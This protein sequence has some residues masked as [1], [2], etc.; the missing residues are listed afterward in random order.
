M[1]TT[2][3]KKVIGTIG[4]AAVVGGAVFGLSKAAEASKVNAEAFFEDT[5]YTT[6]VEADS[7][8][9]SE[10]TQI[11]TEAID[12]T[13]RFLYG[14]GESTEAEEETEQTEESEENEESEESTKDSSTNSILAGLEDAANNAQNSEQNG[15]NKIEPDPEEETTGGLVND[16][17]KDEETVSDNYNEKNPSNIETGEGTNETIK[18]T[19]SD[20][21][22]TGVAPNV[23]VV[24]GLGA[25]LL[26]AGGIGL[27]V[28]LG[29][30]NKK[31]AKVETKLN[32]D[33]NNYDSV[34]DFQRD[35]EKLYATGNQKLISKIKKSFEKCQ[36]KALNDKQEAVLKQEYADRAKLNKT[37]AK[38]NIIGSEYD[39]DSYKLHVESLATIARAEEIGEKTE[40]KSKKSS[41]YTKRIKKVNE[42]NEK[43]NEKMVKVA[44]GDMDKEV[45]F[46]EGPT[47]K[48]HA[49]DQPVQVF[50]I[51]IK[52]AVAH[53]T[54][55]NGQSLKTLISKVHELFPVADGKVKLCKIDLITESGEN[56]ELQCSFNEGAG[57][58]I[59][60]AGLFAEVKKVR[61]AR[62][63]IVNVVV[64]ETEQTNKHIEKGP[65]TSFDINVDYKNNIAGL[66]KRINASEETL[67][68]F[69]KTYELVN[70][71]VFNDEKIQKVVKNN[72][73]QTL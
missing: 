71:Y 7:S 34:V 1:A 58:D 13:V 56:L 50:P 12:H 43:A 68:K 31:L 45:Y 42:L 10:E 4:I 32:A 22:R 14:E 52:R 60:K 9:V 27:G 16:A 55:I 36:K 41:L 72:E 18:G 67:N 3:F 65:K 59:C 15:S 25:G 19:F 17:E 8:Y 70:R 63:D 51:N 23:W 54:S 28:G 57:Y 53:S 33:T 40:G 62:N 30:R 35:V 46:P 44:L 73:G 5:T 24:A 47:F 39:K 21:Q 37:T 11:M 48:I 20:S 38:S 6:I 64:S 2:K 61:E 66:V 69:N 29:T 49:G 26:L